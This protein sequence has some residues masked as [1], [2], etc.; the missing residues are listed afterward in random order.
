[1]RPKR[2]TGHPGN[3]LCSWG[4]NPNR[5]RTPQQDRSP[6]PARSMAAEAARRPPRPRWTMAGQR[7]TGQLTRQRSAAAPS[8]RP[9]GTASTA[10]QQTTT[11]AGTATQPRTTCTEDGRHHGTRTAHSAHRRPP[12]G[13]RAANP[14]TGPRPARRAPEAAHAGPAA[15]APSRTDPT[16]AGYR[17]RHALDHWTGSSGNPC[18]Y[19]SLHLY[20]AA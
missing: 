15:P 2:G 8:S 4:R 19:Y 12:G 7:H 10:A 3:V 20:I 1:M 5:D 13:R 9:G 11:A 6:R 17:Q 14:T 18:L 16:P